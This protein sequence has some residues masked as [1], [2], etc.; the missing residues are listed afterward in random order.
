MWQFG[1]LMEHAR[2]VGRSEALGR[3]AKETLQ[4]PS[5]VK[6]NA[7]QKMQM[8]LGGGLTATGSPERTPP[9]F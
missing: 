8:W 5:R 7:S 1:I 6:R 3:M 4:M 2:A 9:G